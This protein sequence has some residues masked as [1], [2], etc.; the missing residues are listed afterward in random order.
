MKGRLFND[1]NLALTH[2]SALS[3]Y[4]RTLVAR[5]LKGKEKLFELAGNSSYRGK[6]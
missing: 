1:D 3:I 2:E 6:F 4:G 5:T